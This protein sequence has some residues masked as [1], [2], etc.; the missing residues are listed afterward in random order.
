VARAL[1]TQTSFQ[2]AP[3]LDSI[4]ND[5]EGGWLQK[6]WGHLEEGTIKKGDSLE[7]MQQQM[8]EHILNAQIETL[9]N[10]Q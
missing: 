1:T 10:H 2:H 5:R 7:V 4:P 3:R 8:L 6:R 9:H